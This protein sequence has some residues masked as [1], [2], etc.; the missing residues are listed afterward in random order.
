MLGLLPGRDVGENPVGAQGA[1]FTVSSHGSGV[2]PDPLAVFA[3]DPKLL[4]E[5]LVL[6][7]QRLKTLNG[8]LSVTGMNSFHQ[9]FYAVLADLFGGIAQNA[10]DVGTHEN[11]SPILCR[12]PDYVLQAREEAVQPFLP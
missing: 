7:K 10:L 1:I 5:T 12:R 11:H 6:G 8:R 4:I 3:L 2:Q 9:E